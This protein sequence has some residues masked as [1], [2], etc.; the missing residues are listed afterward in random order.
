MFF[1]VKLGEKVWR[2]NCVISEGISV[3]GGG[4]GHWEDLAPTPKS[5]G[6]A[7]GSGGNGMV[8]EKANDR[9]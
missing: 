4:G 7:G 9:Q 1:H 6:S 3:R 5:W 8:P 2:E